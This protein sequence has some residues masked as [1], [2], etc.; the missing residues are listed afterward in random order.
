MTESGEYRCVAGNVL[1]ETS[2]SIYLKINK[3]GRERIERTLFLVWILVF[4]TK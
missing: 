4:V 1:G 3:S 2:S